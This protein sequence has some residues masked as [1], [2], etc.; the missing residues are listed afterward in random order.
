MPTLT[1]EGH[2]AKER[3]ESL[4]DFCIQYRRG[5]G[6]YHDDCRWWVKI[7]GETGIIGMGVKLL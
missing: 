6:A 3:R 1:C 4:I 7:L 2:T 5:I